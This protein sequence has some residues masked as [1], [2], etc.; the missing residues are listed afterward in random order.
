[1]TFTK[2]KLIIQKLKLKKDETHA[3]PNDDTV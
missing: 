3:K 1:M 2:G